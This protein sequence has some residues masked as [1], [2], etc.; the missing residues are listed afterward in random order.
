MPTTRQQGTDWS[1][2]C[3]VTVDGRAL[4]VD[5]MRNM[6][7]CSVVH[8][9]GKVDSLTMVFKD[10]DYLI[11]EAYIKPNSTI[12]VRCGWK[13]EQVTKGP[14][15]ITEYKPSFPANDAPQLSINGAS[16]GAT[17]M[18]LNARSKSFNGK[19]AKEVFQEIAI[20]YGLE[21]EWLVDE[22]DNVKFDDNFSLTQAGETDKRLLARIAVKMGGYHWGVINK[23]LFVQKPESATEVIELDYRIGKKTIKSFDPEIKIFTSGGKHKSK[24]QTAFLDFENADGVLGQEFADGLFED[25]PDE[26][27]K[28]FLKDT[29]NV[30]GVKNKEQQPDL[31]KE[32]PP[33]PQTRDRFEVTPFVG[34]EVVSGPVYKFLD[35]KAPN[36][37]NT[38]D[39]N[40]AQATNTEHAT[41]Q[42]KRSSRKTV[43]AGGTLVPTFP[44]W[45]WTAREAVVLRGLS[46]IVNYRFEVSKATLGYD[47]KSGLTT[48][49]ELKSRIPGKKKGRGNDEEREPDALAADINNQ[50]RPIAEQR[51]NSV[52]LD[53]RSGNVRRANTPH[54]NES[55]EE[56]RSTDFILRE[57]FGTRNALRD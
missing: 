36:E 48:S 11:Q 33:L 42:L 50:A 4:P 43:V 15:K 30:P 32:E 38:T 18:N 5:I 34:L 27:F 47:N 3:V 29:F 41:R 9:R 54:A 24:K 26:G 7:S 20:R 31:S 56:R 17:K 28:N 25:E 46:N 12:Y 22:A 51:R 52:V 35:I 10:F 14:F 55:I 2:Q 44:S 1:G 57:E 19:S 40:D 45:A 53:P 37:K 49:L 39:A 6:V 21:L 16:V 23:T 13:T 8:E